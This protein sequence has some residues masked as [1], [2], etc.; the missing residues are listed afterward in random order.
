MSVMEECRLFLERFERAA[1]REPA[2][3]AEALCLN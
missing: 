1:Q 3:T 2:W